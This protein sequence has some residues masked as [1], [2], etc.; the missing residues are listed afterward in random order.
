[1]TIALLLSLG[2]FIV[3]IQSVRVYYACTK[4][5]QSLGRSDYQRS[6]CGSVCQVRNFPFEDQTNSF[7]LSL[8]QGVYIFEVSSK[9]YQDVIGDVFCPG[10]FCFKREKCESLDGYVTTLGS[11]CSCGKCGAWWFVLNVLLMPQEHVKTTNLDKK[12]FLFEEKLNLLPDK[13]LFVNVPVQSTIYIK[14]EKC[15]D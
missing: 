12:R 6:Q 9:S 14:I 1:M 7:F 8:V 2:T 5:I 11:I 10:N 3:Q 15:E 13:Q 4:T